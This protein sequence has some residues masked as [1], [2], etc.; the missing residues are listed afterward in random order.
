MASSGSPDR[1]PGQRSRA[2]FLATPGRFPGVTASRTCRP[3]LR[4]CT[5][6]PRANGVRSRRLSWG[7]CPPVLGA[8]RR[9]LRRR[10]RAVDRHPR[11]RAVDGCVEPAGPRAGPMAGRRGGFRCAPF[12]SFRPRSDGCRSPGPC[13]RV[14]GESALQRRQASA[15]GGCPPTGSR[16]GSGGTSGCSPRVS[17]WGSPPL[18]RRPV[19][20]RG[21]PPT[22]FLRRYPSV[23]GARHPGVSS[24]SEAGRSFPTADPSGFRGLNLSRGAGR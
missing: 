4:V 12:Q 17:L 24:D 22:C 14:V 20:S 15:S 18:R 16:M 6:D 7:L 8:W 10:S 5:H 13:P 21:L 19:W 9:A 2:R 11:V 1:L 3:V 23:C